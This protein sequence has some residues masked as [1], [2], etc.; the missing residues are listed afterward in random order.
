LVTDSSLFAT[1]PKNSNILCEAVEIYILQ[2]ESVASGS[3]IMD[4]E[5]YVAG[6]IIYDAKDVAVDFEKLKDIT[7]ALPDY[8]ITPY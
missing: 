5:K 2:T 8:Y 1:V 3:N 4:D 7:K 6:L